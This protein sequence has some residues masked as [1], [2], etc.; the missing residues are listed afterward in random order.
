MDF[1][2]LRLVVAE[3]RCVGC[4]M[5]E[6][7]CKTVNDRIAIK[8]TPARNLAPGALGLELDTWQN[9]ME[10]MK[11]IKKITEMSA[12]MARA[13]GGEFMLDIPFSFTYHTPP[14]P[15]DSDVA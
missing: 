12:R 8:V 3:E 11:N 9:V 15:Q 10:E 2:A 14:V 5:C 6:Q 7:I 4:G 1:N 13:N